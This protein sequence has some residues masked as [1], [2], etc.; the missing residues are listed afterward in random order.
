MSDEP[1]VDDA[2]PVF[3]RGDRVALED[4][5]TGTVVECWFD[6]G[7]GPSAS[8][9]PPQTTPDGEAGWLYAVWTDVPGGNPIVASLGDHVVACRGS[10]LSALQ[11]ADDEPRPEPN[12]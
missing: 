3:T 2:P 8:G 7:P 9:S 10:D 12:D 6:A 1:A 4:G 11:G 5:R